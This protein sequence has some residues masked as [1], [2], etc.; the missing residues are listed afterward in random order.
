M[1]QSV[2]LTTPQTISSSH[3]CIFS[4]VLNI[5]SPTRKQKLLLIS[6]T[7]AQNLSQFPD[8]WCIAALLAESDDLD[9]S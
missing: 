3:P 8:H 4:L 5:C 7:S 2:S 1:K 9:N 6:A